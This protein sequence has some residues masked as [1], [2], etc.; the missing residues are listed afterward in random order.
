MGG[1]D[2]QT[3]G[4]DLCW[5]PPSLLF[6]GEAPLPAGGWP[7]VFNLTQADGD[8]ISLVRGIVCLLAGP[9]QMQRFQ[10]YAGII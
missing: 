4:L 3:P 1:R 6:P 8:K 2:L 9:G 5:L 10:G 7:A